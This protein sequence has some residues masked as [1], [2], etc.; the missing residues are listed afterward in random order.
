MGH[1]P[2]RPDA[3]PNAEPIDTGAG[4]AVGGGQPAAPRLKADGYGGDIPEPERKP[5]SKAPSIRPDGG[6]KISGS[7]D[8]LVFCPGCRARVRDS[9]LGTCPRC[10]RG[11]CP[12]CLP[13]EEREA[14]KP[15]LT[16][17][18]ARERPSVT[19]RRV[20]ARVAAG[21]IQFR[22]LY[23]PEDPVKKVNAE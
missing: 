2:E 21:E 12:D 20:L 6:V 1:F 8:W 22:E 18:P 13:Q 4:F 5:N 15:C 7:T 10:V 14:G 17:D 16:C 11:L 3:T 23:G 19:A 9:W